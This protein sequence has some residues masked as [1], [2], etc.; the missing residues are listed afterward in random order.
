MCL[1]LI[2]HIYKGVPFRLGEGLSKLLDF[3]AVLCFSFFVFSFVDGKVWMRRFYYR[4]ILD[5]N[6]G[7]FFVKRHNA[8]QRETSK[9]GTQSR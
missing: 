2:S 1:T 3:F 8:W 9:H 4:G 6:G 5:E 7:L